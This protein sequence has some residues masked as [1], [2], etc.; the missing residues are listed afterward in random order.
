M[1][2]IFLILI[3]CSNLI[4]QNNV[5]NPAIKTLFFQ[6]NSLFDTNL[7]HTVN[8]QKYVTLAI[9]DSLKAAYPKLA[10]LDYSISGQD[11]VQI[12]ALI[13]SQ[14]TVK[15]VKSKDVIVIWEG[16]NNLA[17]YS[18]KTGATAFSE[19]QTFVNTVAAYTDKYIVCTTI[20]RD[21][22]G[23]PVDLMTRIGDYNT[24]IRANYTG[25]HLCDLGADA[26]FDTRADASVSPPYDTDK[27]HLF[28]SGQT[29][30]INLVLAS[31]RLVL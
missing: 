23:D 2:N 11:Q 27:L 16:T 9:Y 4:A 17:H 3:F 18:S 5:A 19:L 29:K 30:I 13:S 24:L 22:S 20:A 7:N 25:N 15:M 10:W 14:F 28:Q 8:N 1:R 12:N 31:I 26:M 6:G 21:L